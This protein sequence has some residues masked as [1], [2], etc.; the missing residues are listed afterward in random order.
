MSSGRVYLGLFASAISLLAQENSSDFFETRVRPVLANSCYSCHASSQL[1]GLRLDSRVAM[2]Q[3][4]KSG[5]AIVPGRP[6]DS[7][8]IRAIEQ[9]DPK[10]KM[11]MSGQKLKDQE[12]ADLKHWIQI[13]APWPESPAGPKPASAAKGFAITP[14]QRSFW[15]FQPLRK[16]EPPRVKD[17][18]WPK[19]PVDNFVLAKLDQQGLTPVKPA[20]KRTLLRRATFD[21]I[22]LPPTPEEV[23]AFLADPSPDAFAKVVDRLLASPHYGERWARHWLDVARYADG[24]GGKDKRPVFIG[25]GM[26]RDGYANTWRYRDWVVDA[27]N[28]D[29]P[30]DRFVKAQIA[31]DLLPDK[32]KEKLLPGLGFFGLG[33]WFT[34]DDVVFVEARANERD[35]KIDTV[36][37]AFLGL[38]VACARCHDHKYDPISQKDYY[39]LG[40]VFGSSGYWEYNLAPETQVAVYKAHRE[41]IKD[42]QAAIAEFMDSTTIEVA[43]TLAGRTSRY[44]LAGRK[45]LLSKA[46]SEEKADEEKLDSETLQRWVSYLGEKERQHPY[47]REW[48]ALMA[49]GGGSDAEAKR[50]ADQFQALVLS[51]IADK[52]IAIAANQEMVRHYKPDANEA[53]ALLPGD[54][55]QFE[56]FQFK[57]QLVQ[58][59]V[60]TS[61]FY[62]WLDVVQGEP[63]SPDYPK[64]R[65]V[66]EYK[67][68]KLLRLFSPEQNSNLDAMRSELAAL[69]K[70]APPEYPYLMG[71][72][73]EENPLNLKVNVRGN[74]HAL[75]D[76]VPRGLP[77]ILAG[78]GG[79]PLPFRNGS[80]RL[81]LADAIVR[82]PLSA[83][84]MVNRIWMEHFGRGIVATPSN[85][86]IMGERP[87]HPELLDYLASRFIGSNW[88]IKALHRE[89]MLSATYRLSGEDSESAA[90]ADPDNRYLWHA[91]LRRLDAEALRDSL[92]FVTGTLDERL[93]GPPRNLDQPDNKKRTVYGR[94]SRG[95]PNRMMLL[96]DFPD[97]NFSADQRNVTNVP[98]QGL[99]FMNSDL[100]WRQAGVFANRLGSSQSDEDKIDKAYRFLYG[101]KATDTELNR[102]LKFLKGA[103]NDASAWQRYAQ[104]LLSSGESY[105][106]D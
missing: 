81:E 11:P 5:P 56:L 3:G 68:E 37:K 6:N 96:F 84:V 34:G 94:V 44:M 63:S 13:G 83:R 86:G 75:G 70:A 102:G 76:E 8:L 41:K 79:E 80:G 9:A 2:L 40:G 18:S 26:A 77:A 59:V 46:A 74:A 49:R 90:K 69:A 10:L 32:D 97:P 20:D 42:R 30:Y 87:T 52:K 66:L 51:V 82:H 1:G 78:T 27:F 14:E 21:L 99:F 19:S 22:G 39:A 35:D 92:L 91:S 85:F 53:Q 54:L 58:K 48:D 101:R 71:I 61:K 4:G 65:A 38:T 45:I 72:A 106:I 23:D 100:V 67:D 95:G 43:E 31:A 24:D 25:Y 93:G 73:D 33:P 28:Q 64:K 17:A 12:I 47:L 103:G 16:P 88:S 57:Q 7:M 104:V 105:Y 62:V 60:E 36:S 98:L 50:L 29:M 55:K 15:S 89:I